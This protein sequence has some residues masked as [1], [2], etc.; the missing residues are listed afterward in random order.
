RRRRTW[1]VRAGSDRGID[2]PAVPLPGMGS[3]GNSGGLAATGAT[4]PRTERAFSQG[5]SDLDGQDAQQLAGVGCDEGDA[6][7]CV[8]RDLPARSGGKLLVLLQ[9]ILPER[10]GI[11]VRPGPARCVL[12]GLRPYRIP[13]GAA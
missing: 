7:G 2:P 13:L 12:E 10:L 4:L 11:H 5:S 9:T 1:R 6:A 8:H 3:A